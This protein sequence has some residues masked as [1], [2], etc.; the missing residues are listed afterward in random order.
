MRLISCK[1]ST[2]I[3]YLVLIHVLVPIMQNFFFKHFRDLNSCKTTFDSVLSVVWA[4]YDLYLKTKSTYMHFQGLMSLIT[5]ATSFNTLNIFPGLSMYFMLTFL[6]SLDYKSMRGAQQSQARRVYQGKQWSSPI[7]IRT[8]ASRPE[9]TLT[10]H[11]KL[12]GTQVSAQ[13]WVF[14]SYST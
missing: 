11:G 13:V 2:G 7:C 10:L 3:K 12:T 5:I 1:S 4:L 8:T 9:Y 14:I 6:F